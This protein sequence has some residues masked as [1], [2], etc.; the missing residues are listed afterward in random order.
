MTQAIEIIEIKLADLG[1]FSG[2]YESIWLNENTVGDADDKLT[3]MA[4]DL[5]IATGDIDYSIDAIAYLNSIGKAYI[6]VLAKE[7]SADESEFKMQ[8]VFS[9]REYN[10]LTDEI[11]LSWVAENAQARLDVFL[12]DVDEEYCFD[13][14]PRGSFELYKVYEPKGCDLADEHMSFYTYQDEGD[15]VYDLEA[16]KYIFKTDDEAQDEK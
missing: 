1:L 8:S 16:G 10:F 13:T 11:T 5:G 3:D 2:L 14:Y 9:P 7:L 6:S 12:S 4:N 15:I